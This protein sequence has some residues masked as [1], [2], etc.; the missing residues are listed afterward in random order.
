MK[1]L[2]SF[3]VAVVVSAFHSSA[4]AEMSEFFHQTQMGAVELTPH[5]AYRTATLLSSADARPETQFEGVD[6]LGVQAQVGVTSHAWMGIQGAYSK[7]KSLGAPDLH[8][9]EPLEVSLTGKAGGDFTDLF[10]GVRASLALESASTADPV[11]RS[12]GDALAKFPAGGFKLA[13]WLGLQRRFGPGLAGIRVETDL[14]RTDVDVKTADGKQ[15]TLKNGA[16]TSVQAF[17]EMK[18]SEC[19]LGAALITNFFDVVQSQ[20]AGASALTNQNPHA[21]V[22]AKLYAALPVESP[23]T[24]TW[25]FLPSFQI[26]EKLSGE[27]FKKTSDIQL[28]VAGRFTL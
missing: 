5:A 13:P 6:H 21:L 24:H 3:A 17:Y 14:V 1:A 11:T 18:A 22:G 16:E 9:F 4:I 7:L 12:Y 19:D 23:L 27:D 26:R 20:G 10:F 8:G 25:V 15:L 28:A 2:K